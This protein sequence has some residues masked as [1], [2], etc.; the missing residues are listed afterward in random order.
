MDEPED[1]RYVAELVRDK[2]PHLKIFVRAKNRT[3]AYY[4]LN[5][6]IDNIYRET[7]GT[8]VEMAIDILHETG[9]R[10]YAARRFAKRF[11]AID[12]A[13]IRSLA[14]KVDNADKHNP[15]TTRE[16]LEREEELLAYDSLNFE[17]HDWID[18]QEDDEE[19]IEN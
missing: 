16:A 2:F 14:K 3:D 8:A 19:S 15:F 11:K 6:G 1:N 17:N 7:L 13:S 5:H 10:K 9:M 18:N 4:Y 12:K